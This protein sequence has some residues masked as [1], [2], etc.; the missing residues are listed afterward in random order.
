MQTKALPEQA[1]AAACEVCRQH[2]AA[3]VAGSR[4]GPLSLAYCQ[5]CLAH[6]AEPFWL[7]DATLEQIGSL[8]NGAP[9]L[10]Q[11]TT[12]KDGRYL[13]IQEAEQLRHVQLVKQINICQEPNPHPFQI[14]PPK[15]GD[16]ST[17]SRKN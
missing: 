1:A 8:A 4:L 6:Q 11:I 17:P 9:W 16:E 13:S 7:V 15:C 2:P 5:D 14:P 12:F 3:G 10:Q